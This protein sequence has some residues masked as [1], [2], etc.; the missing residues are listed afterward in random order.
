MSAPPLQLASAAEAREPDPPRPRGEQDLHALLVDVQ[1]RLETFYALEP[2]APVT[3]F[4][5]PEE[6]AADLPG[7]G[8]RTLV[9]QEGDLVSLGVFLE[10][11]VRDG[12]AR[13]DPRRRLDAGNLGDFCTLTEEVSHFVYL[14]FCA[15]ASRSITQLELELQAE[16]DKYLSTVFL[17][18]LQN[19]GAVSSRVRELL[20]RRYRL[21]ERVSAEQAERYR[22]ANELAYRY[23]G[24]LE[25]RYLKHARLADLARDVRRFY[26]MGQRE[27]LERIAELQ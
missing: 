14:S 17:L 18:S 7:G 13:S 16:V 23:C 6:C 20:F 3:D 21:A 9:T 15:L 8:S 11:A 5:I 10:R 25:A 2:Q 4:L 22:A 26:R 19:E 27:K 1:R 24:W 12:I